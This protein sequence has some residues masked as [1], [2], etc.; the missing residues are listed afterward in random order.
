MAVLNDV[1]LQPARAM[2]RKE[3]RDV[4]VLWTVVEG[5]LTLWDSIG[6]VERVVACGQWVHVR[7]GTGVTVAL[8][9]A[10]NEHPLRLVEL[11]VSVLEYS[12][13]PAVEVTSPLAPAQGWTD[14]PVTLEPGVDAVLRVGRLA[15]AASGLQLHLEAG[16]RAYGVLLQVRVP[17]DQV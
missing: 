7:G 8:R 11:H 2:A 13:Q 3:H 5:E 17:Y 9:N 10:S 1:L 12:A 6:Q 14:V 16:R 4:H 15:D